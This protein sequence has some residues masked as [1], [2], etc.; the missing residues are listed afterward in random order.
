M[1]NLTNEKFVDDLLHPMENV[2]EIEFAGGEPILDPIHFNIL[3]SIKHPE[4]VTLKY[5]TNLS[6]LFSTKNMTLL[7]MWKKFKDIKL[8]VS[9]DGN[10]D[11]NYH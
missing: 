6:T 2:E 8:T 11:T 1:C 3:D 5:S 7:G 10:K 4:R 9:I